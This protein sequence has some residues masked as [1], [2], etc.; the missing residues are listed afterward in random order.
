MTKAPTLA[1]AVSLIAVVASAQYKPRTTTPQAPRQQTPAV[2][3]GNPNVIVTQNNSA[4]A[5]QTATIRRM[6][7][8]EASKLVRENKAVIVDVRSK[9]SFDKSH[10]KGA[11]S[12]PNSQ[13]MQR[14]REVPPGKTIITYC[15]C[16]AEETSGAA[17]M[18]LNAHGLKNAAA[19][20]GGIAAWQ[21]AGLAVE[22]T[23]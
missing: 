19:L 18:Q 9:D 12:I 15:S 22:T 21:K 4:V 11:L 2:V 3:G 14:L 1:L 20:V 23:R 17:V 8:A 7:V 5:A 6:G 16:P 10:I 13:L